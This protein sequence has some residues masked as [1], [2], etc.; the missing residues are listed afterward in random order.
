MA[1]QIIVHKGRTVILPVNLGI[2]LSALPASHITS[3]I[4]SEPELAAPLLA[5]WDVAYETDG[6]DGVLILTLDDVITG[7]IVAKS[8]FMD[9][10]RVVGGEPFAVFA[11]P[12]EV[13]FLGSVTA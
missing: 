12:I 6:S 9:L 5:T 1:T 7:Q 8:G 11:Q 4:R 2:D 10:K 13:S 3:E